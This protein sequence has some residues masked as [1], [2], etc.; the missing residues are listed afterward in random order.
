MKDQ[1]RREHLDAERE[2]RDGVV[3][4]SRG[5][6]AYNSVRVALATYL[7]GE[8]YRGLQ[9]RRRGDRPAPASETGPADPQ[10]ERRR[11]ERP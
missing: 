7:A 4:S 1:E 6:G 3:A 9:Q 11:Q 8:R 2:A 5:A 10:A